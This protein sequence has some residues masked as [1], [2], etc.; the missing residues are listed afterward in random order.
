MRNRF[1]TAW[2]LLINSKI[3]LISTPP[4]WSPSLRSR[5]I[6]WGSGSEVAYEALNLIDGERTVGEVRDDLSAIYGPVPTGTVAEY[7]RALERIGIL[8][9][10][11][12]ARRP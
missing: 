5:P 2:G 4:I 11:D 7:L 8:E 1:L 9:R 12:P 6:L 10:I 3:F